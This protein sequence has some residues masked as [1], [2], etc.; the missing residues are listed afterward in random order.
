MSVAGPVP[1]LPRTF[2]VERHRDQLRDLH[3]HM[4]DNGPFVAHA[5]RFVIEASKPV[6]PG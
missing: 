4:A 2:F 6:C 5:S 3:Q 1:R